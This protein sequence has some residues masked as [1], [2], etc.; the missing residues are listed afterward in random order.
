MIAFTRYAVQ[1]ETR[2]GTTPASLNVD[3]N[4]LEN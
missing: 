1:M 4:L 3:N 2:G